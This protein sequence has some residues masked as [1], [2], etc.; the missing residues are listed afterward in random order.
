MQWRRKTVPETEPAVTRIRL[1]AKLLLPDPC[2]AFGTR[3]Y[4]SSLRYSANGAADRRIAQR[5]EWRMEAWRDAT[6]GGWFESDCPE[7]SGPR[8]KYI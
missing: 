5:E 7:G 1:S 2:R 8:K 4:D 3:R 6:P